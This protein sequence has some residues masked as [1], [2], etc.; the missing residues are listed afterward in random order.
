MF[1][2]ITLFCVGL[3]ERSLSSSESS[4]RN[5]EGRARNVCETELVAELNRGGVATV[6]AA[7]TYV[8]LGTCSLTKLDSCLHQLTNADLVELSE[9]IVLEDLC[10]VVSI[11]ELTSVVSGEAVCHLCQVVCTEAEELSFLSD[12]VSCQSCTRNLD[13]CTNLVL[14][15]NA[16]SSDYFVSSSNNYILNILELLDLAYEGDHDLGNEIPIGM[17]LL[18]IDSSLDNCLCLHLCDLGVCYSET[19]STVTHHGV[20]L[21]QTS[22]DVLDS[23]NRLA[24]CSSKSSDVSFLCGNEFVQRRIE[25]SDCYR[26][27][28]KCLVE[29]LEVSLLDGFDLSKSCLTL[30]NCIST[31]HLTECSD[32]VSLEEHMLCTAKTD[33]LSAQLASLLSV[34]GCI[35]VC[36][37]LQ[38][39]VLVSPSHDSAELASDRSV[40][41]GDETVVDVTCCTV[42][43]DAV[44]LVVGLTCQLELLVIL[45]HLDVAAAGY[46][47]S[48][49][50]TSNY[51]SVRCHTATYC[52]DTLS[53]LHT[54]DILGGCLKSY[55]NY[56]LATLCPSNSVVSSEYYLTASSSGGSTETLTSGC[57]SLKSSSVELGVEQCVEVSGVDHQN[58]FLLCSHALVNEVASDLERSLSCSLTVTCLV[59]VELLVLNCELHILHISVVV[60]QSLANLL[61]LLKSSGELLSHLSDRHGSTNTGNYV[62]ALCVCEELTHEL[63]LTCSRVTCKC[64]TGTTV[65]THVTKC[66]HLYVNSGTPGV[67]DIVVAAVNVSSGVIPGTEYC[68]NSTHQLILRI[69]R[70]FLTLHSFFV[71]SLELLSQI[72]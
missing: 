16:C 23:L 63:L 62:L 21:V 17:S 39:S 4:N 24:L 33:T 12:I 64:N 55:E 38:N 41:C 49:H 11:E 72:L 3:L 30:L 60:L 46:T 22:D 58:S 50:T 32:S 71:Y 69:L 57:C 35:S 40:Y 20:E 56:L 26:V 68:L 36:S 37:Y 27:T 42:D 18:N 5:T 28:L 10:I 29:S 48:T 47:A 7:D 61:E 45:V 8:E 66:H 1:Y 19:A 14:Q 2:T 70:E 31:D 65:I 53:S 54:C 51:G 59:H 9:G 15:L 13:H 43:R 25:E 44:A 52:Q 6:L 67:R 34:S